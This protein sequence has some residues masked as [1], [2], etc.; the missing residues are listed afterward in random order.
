M[1]YRV[2]ISHRTLH[3]RPNT[4]RDADIWLFKLVQS[5]AV[6]PW[7][8]ALFSARAILRALGVQN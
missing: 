1:L 8:T 3:R 7:K 4:G 2:E 6:F 5:Q